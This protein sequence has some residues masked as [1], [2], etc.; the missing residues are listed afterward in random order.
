MVVSTCGEI[1][2]TGEAE[3]TRRPLDSGIGGGD[4]RISAMSHPADLRRVGAVEGGQRRD[5]AG[6]VDRLDHPPPG[7]V[8]PARSDSIWPT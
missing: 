5:G 7:H 8:V 4:I 3:F 1:R 2:K 6:L